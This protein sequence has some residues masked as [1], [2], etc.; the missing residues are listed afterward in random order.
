MEFVTDDN[1]KIEIPDPPENLWYP[2]D[3]NMEFELV[4][5]GVPVD[6]DYHY[7]RQGDTGDNRSVIGKQVIGG[8]KTTNPTWIYKEKQK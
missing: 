2:P 6:G 8:I 5:Y 1:L 7:F 4:R 3:N